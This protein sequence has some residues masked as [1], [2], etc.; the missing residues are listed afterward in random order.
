MSDCS[1]TF[2][3]PWV[4][5]ILIVQKGV[6]ELDGVKTGYVMGPAPQVIGDHP[7]AQSVFVMAPP[8]IEQ[9]KYI[10]GSRSAFSVVWET[11]LACAAHTFI[12]ECQNAILATVWP[13][14]RALLVR[15][16]ATCVLEDISNHGSSVSTF[17]P[18]YVPSRFSSDFTEVCASP[19][20]PAMAIKEMDGPSRMRTKK[21][22]TVSRM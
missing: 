12:P 21:A 5:R 16:A 9:D 22:R 7:D 4:G 17:L 20:F 19:A 18:V 8:E 1:S 6:V 2:C 3:L 14:G 15:L 10:K 13:W 11:H